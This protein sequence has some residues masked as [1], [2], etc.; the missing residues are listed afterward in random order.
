MKCHSLWR[1][2]LF[3]KNPYIMYGHILQNKH[4]IKYVLNKM[5]TDFSFSSKQL[6]VAFYPHKKIDYESLRLWL[7]NA[8]GVIM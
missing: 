8:W 1:K 2:C 7:T 6:L 5:C 4:F 3:I